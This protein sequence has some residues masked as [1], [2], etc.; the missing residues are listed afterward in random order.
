VI[1]LTY[2][3]SYQLLEWAI[4]TFNLLAIIREKPGV[5]KLT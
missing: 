4:G 5:K 1:Q 2:N 3:V